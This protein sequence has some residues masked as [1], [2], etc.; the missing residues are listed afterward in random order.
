MPVRRRRLGSSAVRG[1]G[2]GGCVYV[3]LE[4]LRSGNSRRITVAV[5]AVV[6]AVRSHIFALRR[7]RELPDLGEGYAAFSGA[8]RVRG[9]CT[10]RCR[11]ARI[12]NRPVNDLSSTGALA[13]VVGGHNVR[14]IFVRDAGTVDA[15]A[16]SSGSDA[17]DP[18]VDVGLLLGQ[19]ASALLLI[20]KDECVRGEAFMV[21]GGSGGL[22]V[23]VSELRRMGNGFQFGVEATVEEHEKSEARGFDG[24]AVAG[25]S[26][27]ALAWRIVEPVT[28][29][30]KGLVQGFQIGI[31]GIIIAVEAEVGGGLRRRCRTSAKEKQA[32]EQPCVTRAMLAKLGEGG[33]ADASSAQRSSRTFRGET[34]VALHPGRGVRG[35]MRLLARYPD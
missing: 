4:L 3:Y 21:R 30:G 8:W 32:D 11:R 6:G 20:E 14:I 17:V 18:S 26:V 15:G 13:N 5:T 29:V 28:G 33:G 23:R 35:S 9:K 12:I 1:I 2:R 16:K 27:R 19:H 7:L 25:P 22:R 31:A 24:R 10:A 34:V